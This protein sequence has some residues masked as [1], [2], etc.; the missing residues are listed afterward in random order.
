PV[1]CGA[2]RSSQVKDQVVSSCDAPPIV[3][4]T[5]RT[6]TCCKLSKGA[7]ASTTMRNVSGC[8]FVA[9]DCGPVK[10]GWKTPPENASTPATN[11]C[12][13]ATSTPSTPRSVKPSAIGVSM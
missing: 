4:V 2:V 5:T 8:G 9:L 7:S 11:T 1:T 6:G 10:P 12:V 3:C 13:A